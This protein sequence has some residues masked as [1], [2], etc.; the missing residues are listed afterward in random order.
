MQSCGDGVVDGGGAGA[1]RERVGHRRG[2]VVAEEV[3]EVR[4]V[5]QGSC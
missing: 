4:G 5:A 1:G 2:E 3:G